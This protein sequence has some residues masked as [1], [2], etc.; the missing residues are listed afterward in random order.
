MFDDKLLIHVTYTIA[1]I[2][3]GI[4]LART[5][6]SLQQIFT[7]SVEKKFGK[8]RMHAGVHQ[9]GVEL[10]KTMEDHEAMQFIHVQDQ[11]KD[12]R[13]AYGEMTSPCTCLTGIG[14]TPLIYVEAII[15]MFECPATI[16]PV[17][18]ETTTDEFHVFAEKL[19]SDALLPFAKINFNMMSARK[20]R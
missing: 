13:L 8:T 16:S 10:I 15:H 1:E 7:V 6:I 20:R 11:V 17:L 19:M 4:K 2:V 9:T 18:G 3:H 5:P 12:G 14:I